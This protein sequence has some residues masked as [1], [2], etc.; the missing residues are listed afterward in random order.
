MPLSK[1]KGNAM[2]AARQINNLRL[3]VPHRLLSLRARSASVAY[4]VGMG[5]S[6]GHRPATESTSEA[7]CAP[8]HHDVP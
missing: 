7:R 2:I 4:G 6:A 5:G 1:G 8:G 3:L